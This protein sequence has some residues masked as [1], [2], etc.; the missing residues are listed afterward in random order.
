MRKILL[1]IFFIV[2]VIALVYKSPFSALYNYNKAKA[3][4]DSKQYEQSLPYFERSLFASPKGIL[5]RFYYVLALSKAKPS[6]SV[7]KKLF[8][9]SKSTINDEATK[10]AKIQVKALK[11]KLLRGL[12]N[13]YIYNAIN[14]NDILRWDIRS[15]P[16]KV[17]F[18]NPTSV[19]DYYV[20]AIKRAM[21]LWTSNTNFVK[22]VVVNTPESANI[23]VKFTDIDTDCKNKTCRYAVAY[24]QPVLVNDNI[25]K[26]MDLT[27]YR[28]NPRNQSFSNDEVFNTAVHE[29]GHTLGIMG[30]SDNPT[31]LMYSSNDGGIP[32]NGSLRQSLSMRDLNTLVLLYRLEPS[33]SNVKN[34]KSE[35][36]YYAPLILGDNDQILQKKLLEFKKYINM[37]PE[38]ASGYINIA[39]VYSDMGDF[40]SVISSLNQAEKL[41]KNADETYM[42]AYNRSVVYYNMQQYDEALKF[43]KVA[44][45]IKDN[46]SIQDLI[47]DIEQIMN[48]R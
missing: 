7:E 6:Y 44:K 24:T 17:Y 43:A 35:N 9:L 21:G 27:F 20:D 33:I 22:F 40:D 2:L 11:F 30:H 37:Y 38:M 48:S 12:E 32:W 41:A 28:T 36:F 45:S 16:L 23:Y 1:F 5:A 46:Q 19:P 39:S 25:L 34:L 42:I 47:N 4:Y 3:F 18:E 8:D 31:D 26:R 13:N 15:F 29:L 14:G 10:T